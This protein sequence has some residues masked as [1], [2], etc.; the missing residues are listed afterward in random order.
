VHH[1]PVSLRLS[2]DPDADALLDREPLAL[3]LGMLLDQ[4]VREAVA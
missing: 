3:L 4:R 2:Q 1:G